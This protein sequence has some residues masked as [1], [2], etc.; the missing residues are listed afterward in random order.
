M[1]LRV[2]SEQSTVDGEQRAVN[3]TTAASLLLADTRH[4]SLWSLD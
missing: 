2:Y 3:P 1:G 4:L